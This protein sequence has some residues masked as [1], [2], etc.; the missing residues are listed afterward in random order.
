MAISEI[1]SSRTI[2]PQDKIIKKCRSLGMDPELVKSSKL[3]FLLFKEYMFE[4]MK[5]YQLPPIE[6]NGQLT[7][8]YQNTYS[9]EEQVQ[10]SGESLKETFERCQEDGDTFLIRQKTTK[11]CHLKIPAKN[12][13][14]KVFLE[15]CYQPIPGGKLLNLLNVK[16]MESTEFLSTEELVKNKMFFFNKEKDRFEIDNNVDFLDGGFQSV[17][18][19][20]DT[21][22]LEPFSHLP[23]NGKFYLD[24]IVHSN[25]E[26]GIFWNQ[27]H[28]SIRLTSSNGLVYSAGKV[29]N[30]LENEDHLISIGDTSF[31]SPDVYEFIPKQ[32]YE[33]RIRRYEILNAI[34][35]HKL[36]DY[37]EE[38]IQ[39]ASDLT[40][41]SIYHGV[42]ENC[43]HFCKDIVTFSTKN[44]HVAQEA[45]PRFAACTSAVA[46]SKMQ[47]FSYLLPAVSF[48]QPAK[49]EGQKSLYKKEI[50]DKEVLLPAILLT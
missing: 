24:V 14:F 13:T 21:H 33:K 40:S 38:Q 44:L 1:R 17:Q 29:Y 19:I 50:E 45:L 5:Y 23:S 18:D 4:R 47:V 41:K 16:I 27:G 25:K 7:F 9:L 8:A 34:D 49:Y 20:N 43:A 15:Y 2:S 11:G 39:D 46:R 48:V 37:V 42:K 28:A 10:S 35:F 26:P 3:E 22:F 32:S 30:E 31:N 12:L 36:F 6:Q